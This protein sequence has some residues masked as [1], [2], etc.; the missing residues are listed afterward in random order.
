MDCDIRLAIN[1]TFKCLILVWI[2]ILNS[3]KYQIFNSYDSLII[4]NLQYSLATPMSTNE[5]NDILIGSTLSAKAH[6]TCNFVIEKN[7]D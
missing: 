5:S 2:S 4:V 1:K 6:D 3:L 7:Y